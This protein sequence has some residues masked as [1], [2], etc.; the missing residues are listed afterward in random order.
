MS[1][2]ETVYAQAYPFF[3]GLP[4]PGRVRGAVAKG[5]G[6]GPRIE[7][8]IAQKVSNLRGSVHR[9]SGSAVGVWGNTPAVRLEGAPCAYYNSPL[10]TSNVD[11]RRI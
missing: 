1:R 5:A 9:T 4:H 7:L 6:S 3:A 10:V 8:R 11:S 2:T